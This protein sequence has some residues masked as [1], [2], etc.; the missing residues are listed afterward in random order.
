M[1]GLRLL[2]ATVLAAAP[3][4]HAADSAGAPI[5]G[6]RPPREILAR[7]RPALDAGQRALA[8]GDA[9]A[10][11]AAVAEAVAAL[12]PWAG[13][14]ETATRHYPPP[15]R[16]PVDLALLREPWL[17]EI[18]RNLRGVPWRKNP[19]GNP[20][21]MTA[22]LREAAVPLE[23]LARTA[24]LFP[25][26]RA[27]LEPEVRAGAD[28]LVRLQRAD[29]GFAFPIGPALKPRDKV[30]E[31]V[32]RAVAAR[33][34]IVVEDWIPDDPGDGGLQFDHG[35]CGRALVSAWE[36]TRDP[37]HLAAARR[38]ADWAVPRAMV[39]NWNYNAF[40]VGLLA[41]VHGATGEPRYLAA[42]VRKAE[43]G[44]LPGQLPGGRWFDAHNACAVYHHILLRDLL[45]LARVLP[46]D[47]TFRPALDDALRRG[48]DQAA[49]ETLALGFAGT[50]TDNF[51]VALR[52]L[53]ERASW[54]DALNVCLN[55]A[56]RG[57]A[58]G[59]G[60]ASVP[61]LELAARSTP[62]R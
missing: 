3:L 41:R 40:S 47:H 4:S 30:G 39:T 26:R 2:F 44:V 28:W 19:A 45:E 60:V 10:V 29:G 15:D 18:A 11:R 31:I 17:A 13:N 38:A 6:Q 27:A 25:E 21:L 8:A 32:A 7:V 51:A 49:G 53:G 58:P 55:A 16:A 59:L 24:L 12:G 23:A 34:E 33:P 37:R 54:R 5:P 61:V 52:V 36:L 42:A 14:P 1:I 57:G 50:W 22:G 56:G 43:V 46:A 35:L 9:A 20:R 48:L 62:V